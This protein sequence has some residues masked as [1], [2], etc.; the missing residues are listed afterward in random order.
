MT[1]SAGSRYESGRDMP[2]AMEFLLHFALTPEKQAAA[3][4]RYLRHEQGWFAG[5]LVGK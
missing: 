1:H 2:E 5:F 4:L 3:M